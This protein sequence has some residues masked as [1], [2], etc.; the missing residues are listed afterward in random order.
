MKSNY[1]FRF[2]RDAFTLVE[3]LVVIGIISMLVLLMLP[4]VNAARES[5][6]RAQCYSNLAALVL[7]VHG[8]E[9]SHEH[10]PAGVRDPSAP[11]FSKPEG[12]HHSWTIDVLPYLDE[13]NLFEQIDN[14]VSVYNY[15]DIMG[16]RLSQFTCPS[17]T[18]ESG[19]SAYAAVHHDVEAQIDATNNGVFYLNSRTSIDDISD[20]LKYTFFLGEKNKDHF[21]DLGW[22]SGTRATLRNTGTVIGFEIVTRRPRPNVTGEDETMEAATGQN[23]DPAEPE[24]SSIAPDSET[25]IEAAVADGTYVGGF[26]SQHPGGALFACGDGSVRFIPQS[27][28]MDVYQRYGNRADGKLIRETD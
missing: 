12:M 3:L 4:A 19:A 25:A 26:G 24:G 21:T 14:N 5:S 13:A 1:V 7:A 15:K 28:S 11:V 27:V 23:V 9:S 10:Y 18:W 2:S 8:Y 22:L 16:R 17:A 6:R 20:G